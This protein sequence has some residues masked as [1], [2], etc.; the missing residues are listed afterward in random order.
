MRLIDH[1][2]GPV[3][4]D[5]LMTEA[6]RLGRVEISHMG[7]QHVEIMFYTSFKSLVYARGYHTDLFEAFRI[8]I[9]EARRMKD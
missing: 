4:L 1:I 5:N 6:S 2:T 9:A 3:T 8:A 7:G